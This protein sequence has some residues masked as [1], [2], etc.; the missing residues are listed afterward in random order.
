MPGDVGYASRDSNLLQKN[1]TQFDNKGRF[2]FVK[3]SYA[4]LQ[5][6]ISTKSSLFIKFFRENVPM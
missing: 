1:L 4:F 3:K 5:K 2:D 6:I